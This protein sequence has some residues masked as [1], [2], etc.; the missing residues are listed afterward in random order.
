MSRA[1]GCSKIW[2]PSG[3]SRRRRRRR[4][5]P[6]SQACLLACDPEPKDDEEQPKDGSGTPGTGFLG[7]GRLLED[8]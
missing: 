3:P 2:Y 1:E 4:E 8:S 5:G 6:S 7:R